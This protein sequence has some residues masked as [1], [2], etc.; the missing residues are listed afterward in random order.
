MIGETEQIRLKLAMA[1][2]LNCK[3]VRM[4]GPHLARIALALA[5]IAA[6]PAPARTI[7]VELELVLAADASSSIRGDEFALQVGGYAAAFRDP[8]VVAAIE[9][10][11]G[12]GIA[13]TFVH[14]SATFQQVDVVPWRLVRNRAD[15]ERF[16]ASIEQQARRFTTFGTATGSA[17]EYAAGQLD[18]N[19]FSGRRRVIDISSDERANQGP[20]PGGLREAI[21]ARGITING[22]VVLDD[23]EDLLA[24]FTDYVIGGDGAFVMSVEDYGDFSDAIKRKL[25]REIQAPVAGRGRGRYAGVRKTSSFQ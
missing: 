6:V 15:A 1:W 23:D 10:L 24:Y 20:H 11:G 4:A 19:A 7:E 16:A 14:W 5:L 3:S 17:I 21:I 22:L 18:T 13:V 2:R 9:R 8:S 12:N 25:I